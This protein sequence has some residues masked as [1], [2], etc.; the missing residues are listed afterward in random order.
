M[1]RPQPGIGG[2][3]MNLVTILL[4]A[5]IEKG[6][7]DYEAL[8]KS[9]KGWG[10]ITGEDNPYVPVCDKLHG[11]AALFHLR[12]RSTTT[13]QKGG[14]KE[15][16]SHM[17]LTEIGYAKDVLASAGIAYKT[18]RGFV[19]VQAAD[20][21]AARAALERAGSAAPKISVASP[22]TFDPAPA[23]PEE[24]EEAF[25]EAGFDVAPTHDGK[26][27][28]TFDAEHDTTA[29]FEVMFAL[30]QGRAAEPAQNGA[31]QEERPAQEREGRGRAGH[32][33][34][35]RDSVD[36]GEGDPRYSKP[37]SEQQREACLAAAV[38]IMEAAGVGAQARSRMLSVPLADVHDRRGQFTVVA[39]ELA[40]AKMAPGD[41]ERLIELLGATCM[42]EAHNALNH[43]GL[44]QDFGQYVDGAGP[45]Q[46]QEVR[47]EEA[48]E[49][50]EPETERARPQ[51]GRAAQ[52]GCGRGDDGMSL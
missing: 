47:A 2:A 19:C 31:A 41:N 43:A 7:N 21:A 10:L 14:M 22:M 49:Q 11:R 12:P 36:W 39:G 45:E 44:E 1:M 40:L 30:R 33:E 6:D 4:V 29:A 37:M 15:F 51:P 20:L 26:V 35:G 46:R 13:I 38:R 5:A 25:K 3:L 9:L 27:V 28:V 48:A 34:Y 24:A 52:A 18:F 50:P 23:T 42:G 8:A 32:I 17:H 16:L